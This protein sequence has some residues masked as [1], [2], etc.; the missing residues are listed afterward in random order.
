MFPPMFRVGVLP[1]CLVKAYV[2][3][4][5]PPVDQPRP[6]SIPPLKSKVRE[7]GGAGGW[8]GAG[9]ETAETAA[10]AARAAVMGETEAEAARAAAAAVI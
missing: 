8:G 4:S 7:G 3:G 2:V 9:A 5:P 10:A 1:S 6:K